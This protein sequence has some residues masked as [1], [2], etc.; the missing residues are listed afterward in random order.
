MT[1]TST[2][3]TPTTTPA[4]TPP[5]EVAV[6][7]HP[8]RRA[9]LVSGAVAAAATTAVAA[10]AD[11][12][13]VPLAIDGETIPL[14]GFAQL[15]L[16]G[17]VIG[18]LMAAALGRWT[19]RSRQWFVGTAVLLTALSCIP[20]VTTPPDVATKIVLVATHVLAAAIIVPALARQTSR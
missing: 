9:T 10:V 8:V 17:A 3:P 18:G 6:R 20:S 5:A 2:T 14:L 11:A 19:A 16:I 12:A 13:G 1:A 4:A 15:T 7:R